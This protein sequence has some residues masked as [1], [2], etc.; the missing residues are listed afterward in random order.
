MMF[1]KLLEIR[2]DVGLNVYKYFV[3]YRKKI[4]YKLKKSIE[5]RW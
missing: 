4:V 1:G 5:E 2:K 3:V